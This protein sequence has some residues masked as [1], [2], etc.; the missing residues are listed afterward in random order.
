M[1]LCNETSII[2][3]EDVKNKMFQVNELS[4]MDNLTYTYPGENDI[5]I[6]GDFIIR[7]GVNLT[8]DSKMRFDKNKAVLKIFWDTKS[9]FPFINITNPMIIKSKGIPSIVFTDEEPISNI[10]NAS[11]TY[12]D[13]ISEPIKIM[14]GKNI[15]DFNETKFSFLSPNPSFSEDGVW[16]FFVAGDDIENENKSLC[17]CIYVNMTDLPEVPIIPVPTATKDPAAVNKKAMISMIVI[18]SFLLISG[19]LGFFTRYLKQNRRDREKEKQDELEKLK[20]ERDLSDSSSKFDD[21]EVTQKMSESDLSD[22]ALSF[23][24]DLSIGSDD[25]FSTTTV[26]MSINQSNSISRKN[27]LQ[28]ESISA[29]GVEQNFKTKKKKR[30]RNTTAKTPGSKSRTKSKGDMDTPLLKP[31]DDS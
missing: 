7:P 3:R 18:F 24:H 20:N 16:E 2:Y 4:I 5:N 8:V 14:C 27:T 23:E 19:I 29:A 26:N 28:N 22:R 21:S 10:A 31:V 13:I 25:D 12:A 6:A 30:T 9:G 17:K 15:S 11:E 1:N